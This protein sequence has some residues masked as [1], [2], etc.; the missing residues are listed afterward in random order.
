MLITQRPPD[1]ADGQ[2]EADKGP[3]PLMVLPHG[4]H[5]H[6]DEDQGLADAA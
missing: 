3:V 5:A 1:Q 6:E 2:G 4:G